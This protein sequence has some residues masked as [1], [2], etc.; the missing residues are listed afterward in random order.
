MRNFRP[1]IMILIMLT[2]I[3]SGCTSSDI[4]EIEDLEK[5]IIDLQQSNDN[6]STQLETAKSNIG[7]FNN[8]SLELQASL[9]DVNDTVANL[10]IQINNNEAI[11]NDTLSQRDSLQSI[12]D[13]AIASNESTFSELES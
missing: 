4:S 9:S 2:S 13:E 3:L 7:F 10:N 11:L 8:L 1:L 12:L 5:Q 6:L